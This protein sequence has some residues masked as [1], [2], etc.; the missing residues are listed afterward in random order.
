LTIACQKKGKEIQLIRIIVRWRVMSQQVYGS[1]KGLKPSQIRDV[2]R[3]FNR[4]LPKDQ[5]VSLSFARELL[6]VALAIGRRVGVLVNREGRIEEVIVGTR[7][8]LYLPD[9]GRYRLGSGRL[10]RLRLLFSDLSRSGT[11]AQIPHD[12]YTDLEKLRLDCVVSLREERGAVQAKMAHLMPLLDEAIAPIQVEAVGDL[13]RLNLDFTSFI[14]GVEQE[15]LRSQPPRRAKGEGVLLVGVYDSNLQEAQS[16][17]AELRELARTAGL[18]VRGEVIQRRKPDPRTLLGK[19]KLEEVILRCLRHEA[20][21]L[22]FDT[23]L[24]PHQWRVITNSTELKVLDRSMLILDIFAQ[25]ATSRDGKVQVELA[26]LK[27]NLPRLVEKDVGLSRLTGGIGGR[28]PGETKLEIGRRRIRDRVRQLEKEIEQLQKGR[29]LRRVRREKN[30][31]PLVSLLGY[32]NVG[33]SSLF[34]RLTKGDVLAEDKLFATL[35]PSQRQMGLP[36]LKENEEALV[37]VLSDTVGFIRDLPTELV[38]AFRATLE[39][40]THADLLIHVADVSDENWEEKRASVE[41]LLSEIKLGD[42]PILQ[43]GNKMDL[44]DREQIEALSTSEPELIAVSA[45]SGDGL[46]RLRREIRL[47]L[48]GVGQTPRVKKLALH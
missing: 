28:G 25:R 39:E 31:V 12:I 47:T 20:E 19:G 40:L 21:M 35:D 7:E 36:P 14:E 6:E 18:D 46:E 3:L 29:D 16:S 45:I 8:I 38:N 15:L 33:K 9:L 26:Q 37:V 1:L 32:T 23:E 41:K 13:G 27:Y 24:K 42:I 11:E 44:V 43:V 10:R 5:L 22:V 17:M 48:S 4:S 2:E 34:N 30:K